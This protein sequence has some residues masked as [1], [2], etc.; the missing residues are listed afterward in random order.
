M[1]LSNFPIAT[2]RNEVRNQL[3]VFA[4]LVV[5][6]DLTSVFESERLVFSVRVP[7]IVGL[8]VSVVLIEGVV[9]VSINP[10]QLRNMTQVEWHLTVFLSIVVVLGSDGVESLVEVRV[11]HGVTPV[12]VGLLPVVVWHVR[13]VKTDERHLISL[14]IISNY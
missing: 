6:L 13:L 8:V 1:I 3:Q 4:L 5:W 2:L 12:V 9:Q 10:R 11:D 14:F 7:V